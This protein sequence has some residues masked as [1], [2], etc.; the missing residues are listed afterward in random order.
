ME[1]EREGSGV[2]CAFKIYPL[3][4]T[5]KL[6]PSYLPPAP[7][8]ALLS[9]RLGSRVEVRLFWWASLLAL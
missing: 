4:L 1:G 5:I 3:A 7:Q 8:N 2:V 9:R 6:T